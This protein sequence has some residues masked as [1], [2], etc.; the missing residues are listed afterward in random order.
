L[1][2][3]AELSLDLA[4]EPLH[5]RGYRVAMTDAPLK[6]TLAAA[7]LALGRVPLDLPLVDPM[8]GSGTLA[9]EQALAARRMAPGLLR[10]ALGFQRWP[11]YRGAPQSAWD[12]MKEEARAE[13]LPR[14]PAPI[15]ARDLSRNALEATQRNAAAA[16]VADD[17][18]LEAGD[19]RELSP[20]WP[21]GTLALNPPYGERLMWRRRAELMALYRGLGEALRRHRGWHAVILSGSLLLE[22]ALGLRPEISHRLWNGPIEARLLRV[23]IP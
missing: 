4:G 15:L 22:P 3:E 2:D 13:R 21:K 17:V 20:R 5:R 8:C 1:R 10:P 23:R 14:A 6:E 9:I 11:G 7:V 19:V 18:A 12:R 16:G